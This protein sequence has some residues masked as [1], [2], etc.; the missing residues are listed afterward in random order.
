MIPKLSAGLFHAGGVVNAFVQKLLGRLGV[1][2][3]Q[4]IHGHAVKAPAPVVRIVNQRQPF[5]VGPFRA[6]H[7]REKLRQLHPIF[8]VVRLSLHRL[9]HQFQRVDEM[10]VLLIFERPLTQKV[11]VSLKGYHVGLFA[12]LSSPVA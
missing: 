10:V 12:H 4:L 11:C 1:T 7:L 2:L 8:I 9:A 6:A 5:P 3:G